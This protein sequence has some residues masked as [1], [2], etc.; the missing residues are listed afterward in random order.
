MAD[1]FGARAR[2][3]PRVLMHA[4]DAGCF[5]D[6]KTAGEFRC[7]KCGHNTGWIYTTDAELRRGKPCAT[8]NTGEAAR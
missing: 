3:K 6:G 5:P 1:L 2:R 8:C 7:A 4:I